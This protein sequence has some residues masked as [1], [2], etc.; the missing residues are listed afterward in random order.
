MNLLLHGSGGGRD[1]PDRGR[2]RSQA[3]PGDR[4]DMVLTNPPFGASRR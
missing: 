4:F 3:D 1:Q 2:R